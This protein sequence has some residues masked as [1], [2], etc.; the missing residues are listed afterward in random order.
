MKA[1][2]FLKRCEECGGSSKPT[3][4]WGAEGVETVIQLDDDC[5]SKTGVMVDPAYSLL[6][7]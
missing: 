7:K 3:R 5:A 4:L 1:T 6:G 2:E